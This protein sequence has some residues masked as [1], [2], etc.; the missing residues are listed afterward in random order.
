MEKIKNKKIIFII[1]SIAFF[2]T[3]SL[4]MNKSYSFQTIYDI[5]PENS[6]IVGNEVFNGDI[7]PNYIA[8]AAINYYIE[9]NNET[10][11][12]YKY[13]GLDKNNE[14]IWGTYSDETNSYIELT[15]DEIKILEEQLIKKYEKELSNEK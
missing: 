2:I 9:N 5:I 11:R 14:P 13:S 6:I 1:I 10:V 4:F 15:K 8:N 7:N 3:I 12:I